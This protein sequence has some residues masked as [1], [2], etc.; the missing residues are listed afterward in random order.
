MN[1]QK[2][3]HQEEPTKKHFQAYVGNSRYDSADYAYA[4]SLQKRNSSGPAEL[5]KIVGKTSG[6]KVKIITCK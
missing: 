1:I 5:T 6:S 4:L 2:I 3:K